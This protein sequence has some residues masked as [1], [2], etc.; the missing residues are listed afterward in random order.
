MGFEATIFAQN[1]YES[2]EKNWRENF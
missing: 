2:K 1:G